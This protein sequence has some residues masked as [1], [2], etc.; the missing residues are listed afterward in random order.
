LKRRGLSLAFSAI[1]E[2]R[3][4]A[5]NPNTH[6]SMFGSFTED[7]LLAYAEKASEAF[8]EKR[9]ASKQGMELT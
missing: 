1:G 4:K 2:W 8:R 9:I 3:V 7:A 5:R 6:R